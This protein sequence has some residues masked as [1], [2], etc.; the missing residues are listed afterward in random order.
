M[1][2][3]KNICY[4]MHRKYVYEYRKNVKNNYKKGNILFCI[5]FN[6]RW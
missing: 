2:K 3:K 5:C 4:T 1:L 6:I